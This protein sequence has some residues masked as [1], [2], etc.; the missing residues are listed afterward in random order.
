MHQ[1]GPRVGWRRRRLR[2]EQIRCTL[3]A[4]LAHPLEESIEFGVHF[5]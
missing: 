2:A 3:R 5:G 1:A 4:T